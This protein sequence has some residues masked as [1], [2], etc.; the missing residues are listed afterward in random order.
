MII[1]TLGNSKYPST[2]SYVAVLDQFPHSTINLYNTFEDAVHCLKRHEVDKIV[3]PAAYPTDKPD[4]Y[5]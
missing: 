5:G 4:H 3:I 2:C 1:G